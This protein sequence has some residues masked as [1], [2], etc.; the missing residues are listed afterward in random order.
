MGLFLVYLDDDRPVETSVHIRPVQ[1]TLPS[2]FSVAIF[3][4][5]D[6]LEDDGM[7][8]SGAAGSTLPNERCVNRED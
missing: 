3:H 5:V 2:A 6:M 4:L 8:D 1:G 7:A